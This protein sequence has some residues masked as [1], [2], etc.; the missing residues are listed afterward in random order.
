MISQFQ[1]QFSLPRLNLTF[2]LIHKCI[3]VTLT[4]KQRF[5]QVKNTSLT[6]CKICTNG[7]LLSAGTIWSER[8]S[9]DCIG[10]Y[11]SLCSLHW[12]RVFS[13]LWWKTHRSPGSSCSKQH[14]STTAC[15]EIVHLRFISKKVLKMAR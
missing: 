3:K 8:N 14:Y 7:W 15:M 2:M 6:M 11:Y 10:G 9:R 12:L 13:R 4:P 5:K 1:A